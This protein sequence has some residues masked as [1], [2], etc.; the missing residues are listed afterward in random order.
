M[1]LKVKIF[2]STKIVS[3][4]KIKENRRKQHIMKNNYKLI[5]NT[6]QI[7]GNTI[8][9]SLLQVMITLLPSKFKYILRA[10]VFILLMQ[11][12]SITYAQLCTGSLGD[13]IVNI[14]FG[15]GSNP[16]APLSAATTAYQFRNTDCPPDGFYTVITNT[17]NC[18]NSTW[19]SLANDHT[20]NSNGY[21]MLV[22]ASIQPSAFYVD[23]V[24]GLCGNSTYE[25]AAWLLNILKNTACNSNGIQPNITFSIEKLDGTI[26]QNFNTG[27]IPN[28]SAPIWQQYGFF[29]LTPIGVTDVILRMT[30][31][32]TGGCGNDLALDDITFRPCGPQLTPAII[33]LPSTNG[34]ACAGVAKSFN[35]NCTISAGFN[36]PEYQWQESINGNN[37][38]DIAGETNTTLNKNFLSTTAIG[39]YK[40][41]LT[42]AET[43][44]LG[45]A[46]CR[47]SS[48]P[49]TITV[50]QKPNISI[51]YPTLTCEG[52]T[53]QINATGGIQYDWIGPNNFIAQSSSLNFSNTQ[54]NQA[55]SYQLTI[56]D[57]NGCEN[58]DAINIVIQQKPT[59]SLPYI[60]T[61]ICDGKT[62]QLLAVTNDN[63]EWYPST[64]LSSTS[65]LN[66][67]LNTGD[68]SKY[69]A[70]ATNNFG[71]KDTATINV[72]VLKKPI[73]NAGSDKYF[74]ANRPVV[75]NGS[76]VG[77][78][79]NFTWSPPEF[80]INALQL[81]PT[82]N[83]PT[84]KTYILTVTAKK[85][86]AVLKDSVDVKVYNG[87]FIP[88]A[89]TPNGDNK[90]DIWNVPAL[91]GFPLHELAIYNRYG[92][93]IFQRKQQFVGWDGKYKGI[94]QPMGIYT[95]VIN[96]NNGSPVLKGTLSIIK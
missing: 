39:V 1:R 80:I 19:H 72:H 59:L 50:L 69:L 65:I 52:T 66:P 58:S 20:G 85:G 92:E 57:I 47:I 63:I 42:V 48:A 29:F 31:N 94:P 60:D 11:Y 96:L 67:I 74:I 16:G 6:I 25:F 7:Q 70:I 22:N 26:L 37:F 61:T 36:N 77:D 4:Y 12:Y 54:L 40:Y 5:F 21:F 95:Y 17:N 76:I 53:L 3:L 91:E 55:G 15:A 68:S 62:I 82:V 10:M 83:P 64:G 45:S 86:C 84:N 90:N 32:A 33:G 89:F 13:A 30:N 56:K 88:N 8:A 81:S 9:L 38:L 79:E 14:S 34:V 24:R 93:I 28:T 71:C 87:I 73:V 23:T 49:I 44:N 35:F 46:Q 27:N 2:S 41:R 51:S 78:Y 75:L 43:G 18:F